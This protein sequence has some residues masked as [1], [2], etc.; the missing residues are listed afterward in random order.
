MAQLEARNEA[1]A[2]AAVEKAAVDAAKEKW[3]KTFSNRIATFYQSGL[4]EEIDAARPHVKMQ[5]P[6]EGNDVVVRTS[7]TVHVEVELKRLNQ[8][9]HYFSLSLYDGILQ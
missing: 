6:P 5:C 3:K 2:H 7:L 4:R 9:R 1:E 8:H